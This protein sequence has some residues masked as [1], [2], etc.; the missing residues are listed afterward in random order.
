MSIGEIFKSII[1]H[2]LEGVMFH[3]E[4]ADYYS[5]LSLSGYAAEQEKHAREEMASYRL[6]SRYYTEHYNRL[7]GKPEF[8]DPA[9]IPD[10]WGNYRRQDVDASTKRQAVKAGFEKWTTW[11]TETK[12]LYQS[13]Y[14]ELIKADDYAGAFRVEQLVRS[15]D[16]ELAGAQARQLALELVDYDA[17]YI[18]D[19]QKG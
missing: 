11:E 8:N 10:V 17:V 2:Q 6:M 4:M 13:L 15:V 1:A 7:V 5:F 16:D 18:A 12:A 3:V 9:V 14:K 19:Q